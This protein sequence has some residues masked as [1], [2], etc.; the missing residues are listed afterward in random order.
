MQRHFSLTQQLARSSKNIKNELKW[1]IQW[2][3]GRRSARA[4]KRPEVI[5]TH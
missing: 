1:W 5:A 4:G 3:E 2:T